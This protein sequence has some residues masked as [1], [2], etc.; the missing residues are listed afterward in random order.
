MPRASEGRF[1]KLLLHKCHINEHNLYNQVGLLA[2]RAIGIGRA[3]TSM[4]VDSPPRHVGRTDAGLQTGNSFDRWRPMQQQLPAPHTQRGAAMDPAVV[5]MI[6][7]YNQQKEEAVLQEEY[8]KAK[9]LKDRV[10]ELKTVGVELAELE[11]QKAQFI[12]S[13]DYEKAKQIKQ[14]LAEKREK[15]GVPPPGP[16]APLLVPPSHRQYGGVGGPV[17][18]LRDQMALEEAGA[19]RRIEHMALQAVNDLPLPPV[20]QSVYNYDAL[21]LLPPLPPLLP[22]PPMSK[23]IVQPALESYLG[24]APQARKSEDEE[25]ARR[26]WDVRMDQPVCDGSPRRAIER[27]ASQGLSLNGIVDVNIAPPPVPPLPP[28]P[29]LPP[30]QQMPEQMPTSTE[31]EPVIAPPPAIASDPES[32]TSGA[33][34]GA[35]AAVALISSGDSLQHP[36]CSSNSNPSAPASVAPTMSMSQQPS[37][38]PKTAQT[39]PPAARATA[40]PSQ[41][42]EGTP[43]LHLQPTSIA[44]QQNSG[45][46]VGPSSRPRATTQAAHEERVVGRAPQGLAEQPQGVASDLPP[47]EPLAASDEKEAAALI[48]MFGE[49]RVRCLYS[50]QWNLR[51]HAL[52]QIEQMLPELMQ[53]SDGR[54]V[55]ENVCYVVAL[56]ASETPMLVQV[57]RAA[58]DLCISLFSFPAVGNLPR[59]EWQQLTRELTP[60]LI[61]RLGDGNHR[62]KDASGARAPSDLPPTTIGAGA[63]PLGATSTA[64]TFPG[65]GR[66]FSAWSARFDACPANRVYG[67]AARPVARHRTRDQVGA[68]VVERPSALESD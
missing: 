52:M 64:E 44:T 8:D 62:V 61:S 32:N 27:A 53:R 25:V 68:G 6:N 39:T 12:A 31:V 49:H 19:R 3:G 5:V 16:P 24:A 54:Q 56:R 58:M 35:T 50:N 38:N 7:E 43:Q 51:Q 59:A 36:P 26:E 55:V 15:N 60:K 30:Y 33:M 66:A 2:V 28:L 65:E 22:L 14:D 18:E 67:S 48:D 37:S 20:Q 10:E 13:E 9:F 11:R 1:L 45:S 4:P 21:P 40:V 17:D 23:E 46:N 47:P 63:S 29:P 34:P 57:F 42:P 41:Q